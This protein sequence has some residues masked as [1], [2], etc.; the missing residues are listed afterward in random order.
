MCFFLDYDDLSIE[1]ALFSY[2]E[3]IHHLNK[4]FI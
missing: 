4:L 2:D 1:N 3:V